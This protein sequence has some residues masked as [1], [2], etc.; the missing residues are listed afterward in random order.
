[1]ALRKR[2]CKEEV[3]SP[4]KNPLGETIGGFMAQELRKAVLG[5]LRPIHTK[6]LE[7]ISGGHHNTDFDPSYKALLNL[8]TAEMK[9]QLFPFSLKIT[10]LQRSH[11]IRGKW[12]YAP[13]LELAISPLP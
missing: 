2:D 6:V 12:I 7:R 13:V 10:E 8:Y 1:M 11:L 3:L 9:R 5:Q 4:A